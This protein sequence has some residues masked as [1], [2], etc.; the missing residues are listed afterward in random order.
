MDA[1]LRRGILDVCVLTALRRGES[2]GAGERPA[3]PERGLCQHG[4]RAGQAGCLTSG[5]RASGPVSPGA[6]VLPVAPVKRH[7]SSD[8]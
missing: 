5:P 6:G 1:Q 3:V 8:A 7:S 2:C 4:G